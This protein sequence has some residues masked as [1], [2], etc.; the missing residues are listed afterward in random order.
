VAN[1]AYVRD[2][3]AA[4]GVPVGESETPI[5]PVHT[6]GRDSTFIRWRGLLERG[7]YVNPVVP[8]AASNRLRT[9]FIATHTRRS[10]TMS[11]LAA[12]A[13]THG[14]T[15]YATVYAAFN[16]SYSLGMVLG[17]LAGGAGADIAIG[18][19]L[20]VAAIILAATGTCQ[21]GPDCRLRR[22]EHGLRLV[23]QQGNGT[24]LARRARP[25]DRAAR[26]HRGRARLRNRSPHQFG[27]AGFAVAHTAEGEQIL[28]VST[29]ES[30]LKWVQRSGA[31][32]GFKNAID[33]K[34]EA[35]VADRLRA[36]LTRQLAKTGELDLR[37]T[38]V[39]V[40]G[41]KPQAG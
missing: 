3:L 14:N 18:P 11:Q 38:F 4:M 2:V 41:R 22:G 9:S 28:P 8:P 24:A 26:G 29:P 15:G 6:E 34:R 10:L 30:V 20:L 32:A 27:K 35:E 1:A 36:G 12:V 37:H 33:P 31:A 39:V 23:F 19:T 40:A 17:P 25:G 16:I 7:V 13:R 21:V 5:V